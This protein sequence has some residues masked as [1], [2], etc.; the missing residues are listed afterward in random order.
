MDINLVSTATIEK[1]LN[2]IGVLP[3]NDIHLSE[4]DAILNT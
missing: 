4:I 1:L 2:F 3:G